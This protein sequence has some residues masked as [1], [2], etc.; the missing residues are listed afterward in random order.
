MIMIIININNINNNP[1]KDA[2][3]VQ[4]VKVFVAKPNLSSIFRTH[5]VE[6]KNYK[7]LW[8]P[9]L[10]H[11]R[12]HSDA[13]VLKQLCTKCNFNCNLNCY[14]KQSV[15]R[16]ERLARTGFNSWFRSGC[17]WSVGPILL[18]LRQDSAMTGVQGRGSQ[19][20]TSWDKNRKRAVSR[21]LISPHQHTS[22]W[23]CFLPSTPTS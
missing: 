8:P 20:L 3:M 2:K 19:P 22:Q 7:L 16:G 9:H 11:T 17:P 12:A 4:W 5:T 21:I 18:G 14:P 23:V 15:L 10:W 1:S 13:H 6:E